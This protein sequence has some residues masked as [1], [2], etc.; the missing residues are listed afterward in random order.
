MRILPA[1]YIPRKNPNPVDPYYDALH[2]REAL[3]QKTVE[4][5]L[6][7]H[8]DWMHY[9]TWDSRK[10]SAGFPDLVMVNTRIT[11]VIYAELKTETGEVSEHQALWL[12]VLADADQLVYLW[13]PSDQ[14]DID[15]LLKAI[16]MIG[17]GLSRSDV[18]YP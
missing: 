10:S 6:R 12:N 5:W 9:H 14:P 18:F 17:R 3:W 8:P 13:R 11:I 15:A 4:G 7:P 16:D 1:S 2:P